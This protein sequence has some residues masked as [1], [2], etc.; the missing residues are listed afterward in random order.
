LKKELSNPSIKFLI[1]IET[2]SSNQ[3]LAYNPRPTGTKKL[4]GRDA[5]RIR[6]GNYKVIYEITDGTLH[7]LV[8]VLGH[9]K[10]IYN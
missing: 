4:T 7:V 5:W 2:K 3:A 1:P 8:I 6:I 9:R 10:N